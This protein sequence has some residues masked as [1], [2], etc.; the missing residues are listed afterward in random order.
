M[1]YCLNCKKEFEA[2]KRYGYENQPD[3]KFCSRPCYFEYKKALGNNRVVSHC[4]KCGKEILRWPSQLTVLNYCSKSCANSAN[5][6][7][8][9]PCKVYLP[10]HNQV[11][12]QNCGRIFSVFGYRSH[13]AKYCSKDCYYQAKT[14]HKPKAR[15]NGL[16]HYPKCCA[17]CGFDITV[18]VHHITPRREGGKDAVANLIVLCPNHHAMADRGLLTR[19]E[20][21][22]RNRAA[23]SQ[24]P[25]LLLR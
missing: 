24:L 11:T 5:H 20:L 2:R 10:K 22:Q 4:A 17:V 6:P 21:K 7:T 14:T 23:S 13:I 16:R 3:Q 25:G 15:Q 9:R 12:C 8:N 18:A 1:T 19:E